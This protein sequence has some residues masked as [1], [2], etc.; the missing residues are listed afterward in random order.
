VITRTQ[1]RLVERKRRAAKREWGA[2]GII[3]AVWITAA[4]GVALNVA[5]GG[6]L[7]RTGSDVV[8]EAGRLFGVVTAVLMMSQVLLASRAPWID[9]VIGHDR[10]IARHATLGKYAVLLM[11][12]H[13]SL[14]VVATSH[15]LSQGLV[16]AFLGLAHGNLWMAAVE[17]AGGLFVLVLVTSIFGA[18]RAWHYETWHTI[19]RVVYVAIAIAVP[20]QFLD[21]ETFR[22]GGFAWLFWFVLYAIAFGSFVAFRMVRPMVLTANHR[23]RVAS[24]TTEADGSTTVVI[25]GRMLRGLGAKPGQFLLWRFYTPQLFWQKHPYSLSKAPHGDHVRITVKPSGHGSRAV[26]H[27]RPGTVVTFEGPLGIFTHDAR[28]R[29]GVVLIAAGIGITPIRALLEHVL[30]GEPCVVVVRVRSLD[31]APLLDEVRTLARDRSADLRILVGPRG[32]TWGTADQ[33]AS[34]AE[35]VRDPS[36]VDVFVCGPVAWTMQVEADA[37][38]AGVAPEAIHRERFGW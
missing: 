25:R 27:V 1:A 11:F 18:F 23:A 10:A 19:H 31:E 15:E 37:L 26:A 9:R 35:L 36:D 34:I 8:R 28:T 30:P 32:D 22:R 5:A 21:G 33:P 13:V 17:I 3:A 29:N 38:A 6:L 20:H 24:V 16:T 7:V 2:D 4:V 12:V 14:V